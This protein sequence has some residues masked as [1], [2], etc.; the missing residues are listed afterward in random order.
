MPAKKEA[1]EMKIRVR[2]PQERAK[3][4]TS[5]GPQC[6]G[7]VISLPIAEAE[8]YC[9]REQAIPTNLEEVEA[10]PMVNVEGAASGGE[11]A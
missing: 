2:L 3:I 5:K 6:D 9:E 10:P 11:A 1:E 8:K 4:F 7:A